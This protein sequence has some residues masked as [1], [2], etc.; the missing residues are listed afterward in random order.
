MKKSEFEKF[1]KDLT[2][3]WQQA[4]K[5]NKTRLEI[6]EENQK[7]LI[8]KSIEFGEP[9]PPI[10]Q[11]LAMQ[12]V[13]YLSTEQMKEYDKWFEDTVEEKTNTKI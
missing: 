3:W 13:I 2:E 6:I 9:I 7:H 5:D 11:I 12:S 1:E 10:L 8:A 4:E